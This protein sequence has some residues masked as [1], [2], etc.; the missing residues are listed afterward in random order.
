MGQREHGQPGR[1]EEPDSGQVDDQH[2][3]P[4]REQGHYLVFEGRRGD[5]VN[6]AVHMH[7]GDVIGRA[8]NG[9]GRQAYLR[10]VRFLRAKTSHPDIMP[11]TTDGGMRATTAWPDNQTARV[12]NL[13]SRL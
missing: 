8:L 9:D 3:G 5:H 13:P 7:H 12:S 6:L 1:G 2:S 11:P 10:V 4:L